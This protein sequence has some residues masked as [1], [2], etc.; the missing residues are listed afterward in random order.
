MSIEQ[1]AQ[2]G[3]TLVEQIVFIV[4]V[5]VGV[6]GLISVM[7]PI[8]RQSADAMTTKQSLTIAGALLN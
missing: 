8:I 2:C 3:I 5:S 4:I 6:V 1:R 7:G